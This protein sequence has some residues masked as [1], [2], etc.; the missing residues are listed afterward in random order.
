MKVSFVSIPTQDYKNSSFLNDL[1]K[2]FGFVCK[3]WFK[4]MNAYTLFHSTYCYII[5]FN[6]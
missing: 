6:P 1:Q 5:T 2:L 3:G 4:I